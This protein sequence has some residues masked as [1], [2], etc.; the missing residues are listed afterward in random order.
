M[1]KRPCRRAEGFSLVEL[2]VVVAVL[3]ILVAMMTPSIKTF[4]WGWQIKGTAQKVSILVQKAR[5][6]AVNTRAN[7]TLTFANTG[8]STTVTLTE[9]W[10]SGTGTLFSRDV[11]TLNNEKEVLRI[12]WERPTTTTP[13]TFTFTP[14]GNV[15]ADVGAA[16]N[17]PPR[18]DVYSIRNPTTVKPAYVRVGARGSVVLG[19]LKL[20]AGGATYNSSA[21]FYS[22]SGVPTHPEELRIGVRTTTSEVAE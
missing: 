14:E 11:L 1:R 9:G 18:I 8:T 15:T 20:G 13:V 6:R 4:Y 12:G 3:G 5:L 22:V 17:N 21:G 16:F 19:S 2:L 10:M 7:V